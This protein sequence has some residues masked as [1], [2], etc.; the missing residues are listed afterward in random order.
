[1]ILRF[2]RRDHIKILEKDGKDHNP[3]MADLR[4]RDY[5]HNKKNSGARYLVTSHNNFFAY[6]REGS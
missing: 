2:Q 5:V 6:I 1:M 4:V 3:D